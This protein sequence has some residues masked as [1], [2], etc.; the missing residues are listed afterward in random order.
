MV[1]SDAE[2]LEDVYVNDKSE[3][4]SYWESIAESF[5]GLIQNHI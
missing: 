2:Y 3:Y 4:E 1:A 5:E